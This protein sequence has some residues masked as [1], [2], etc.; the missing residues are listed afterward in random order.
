MVCV[1]NTVTIYEKRQGGGQ[2]GGL[3]SPS[4]YSSSLTVMTAVHENISIEIMN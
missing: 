1:N 2:G 3:K 4:D